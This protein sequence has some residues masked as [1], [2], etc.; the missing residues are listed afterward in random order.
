MSKCDTPPP[1]FTHSDTQILI[2]KGAEMHCKL[3]AR[4]VEVSGLFLGMQHSYL[5]TAAPTRGAQKCLGSWCL[6]I[7][8]SIRSPTSLKFL[9]LAIY[10]PKSSWVHACS[11]SRKLN[12]IRGH[13]DSSPFICRGMIASSIQ[14]TLDLDN[15]K[16]L[17]TEKSSLPPLRPAISFILVWRNR[18]SRR[19]WMSWP[20]AINVRYR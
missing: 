6:T 19:W 14:A 4:T 16:Y 5:G 18:R 10:E 7:L 8:S 13:S 2:P 17:Q 9:I 12:M 11:G 3:T 20:R 1:R 15:L